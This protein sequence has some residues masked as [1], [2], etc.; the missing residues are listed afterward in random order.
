MD[1][2]LGAASAAYLQQAFNRKFTPFLDPVSCGPVRR[3]SPRSP[4]PWIHRRLDYWQ[5]VSVSSIN[6]SLYEPEYLRKI[7]KVLTAKVITVWSASN[8]DGLL[9]SAWLTLLV[10]RCRPNSQIHLVQY[11]RRAGD[12]IAAMPTDVLVKLPGSISVVGKTA[13]FLISLWNAWSS[14]SPKPLLDLFRKSETRNSRRYLLSLLLDR[15]PSSES[16]LSSWDYL[17]LQNVEKHGPRRNRVIAYTLADK[18]RLFD[19]VGSLW[20]RSRLF[21]MEGSETKNALVKIFGSEDAPLQEMIILTPL[22]SDVLSGRANALDRAH[23]TDWIGGVRLARSN[24]TVWVRTSDGL[25]ERPS[26]R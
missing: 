17:L 19:T 14:P 10:H 18:S 15:Y 8:V 20:L 16:G 9:L 5:T 21:L 23:R 7:E 12:T 4:E 22:G 1:L 3:F 6:S 2:T 11:P 13:D 26:N 25:V 24:P